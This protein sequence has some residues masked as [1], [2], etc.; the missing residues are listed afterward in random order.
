MKRVSKEEVIEYRISRANE[1]LMEAGKL[2]ESG[3]LFAAINRLYYCGFYFVT[4]LLIKN[5]IEVKSHAGGR[6]MFGLHFILTG[7]V[8]KSHG[9]FFIDLCE[10]RQDNDYRDF[11]IPDE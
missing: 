5:N 2:F 1:S 3:L 11:I 9:K 6:Q 7:I 4:V 10:Y 8:S